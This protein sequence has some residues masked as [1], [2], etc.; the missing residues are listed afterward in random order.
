V[1]R[2]DSGG[3]GPGQTEVLLQGL[4]TPRTPPL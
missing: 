3:R 2:K 1:D 4:V